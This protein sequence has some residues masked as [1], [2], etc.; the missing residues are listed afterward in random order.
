MF[1]LT[2]LFVTWR[3]LFQGY[4]EI[5]KFIL[6]E[7]NFFMKSVKF[8]VEWSKSRLNCIP[9]DARTTEGQIAHAKELACA[10]SQKS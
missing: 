8:P 10:K 1:K 5:P 6:D 3:V 4:L 7:T 9:L 2:D